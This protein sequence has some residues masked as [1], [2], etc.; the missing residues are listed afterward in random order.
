MHLER[1]IFKK[2]CIKTNQR[3]FKRIIHKNYLVFLIRT[4]CD[5]LQCIERKIIL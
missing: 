1:K 2:E 5:Y 3:Y 4:I